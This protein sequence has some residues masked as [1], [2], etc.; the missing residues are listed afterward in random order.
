[1][2]GPVWNKSTFNGLQ[3]VRGGISGHKAV[4]S[5]HRREGIGG[6]Y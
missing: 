2:E 4:I 1:M 6:T 5:P 3:S